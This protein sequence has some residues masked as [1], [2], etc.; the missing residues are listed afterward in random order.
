[1]KSLFLVFLSTG[2]AFAQSTVPDPEMIF[3]KVDADLSS[4]TICIYIQGKLQQEFKN[5]YADGEL[6]SVSY[7]VPTEDSHTFRRKNGDDG[8]VKERSEYDSDGQLLTIWKYECSEDGS[9]KVTQSGK[10]DKKVVWNYASD[11][12]LKN[13]EFSDADGVYSKLENTYEKGR[14]I[15]SEDNSVKDGKETLFRKTEFSYNDKTGALSVAKTYRGDGTL[16]VTRKYNAKGDLI[17]SMLYNTKGQVVLTALT[18]PEYKD[19]GHGSEKVSESWEMYQ[20][21]K[22]V[23]SGSVEYERAYKDK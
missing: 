2:F 7:T 13:A 23:M 5:E 6:D 8:K 15:R 9:C 11:G 20:N 21:D 14:L 22:M 19:S 3:K 1:M 17:S 10:E 16:S 4:L 18:T 12:K